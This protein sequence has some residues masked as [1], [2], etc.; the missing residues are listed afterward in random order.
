MTLE[1]LA[2]YYDKHYDKLFEYIK[3]SG[4]IPSTKKNN[5]RPMYGIS[6]RKEIIVIRGT[7]IID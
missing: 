7:V 1:E 4:L 6:I 5:I 3:I 2:S